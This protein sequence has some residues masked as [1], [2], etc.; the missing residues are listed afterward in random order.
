MIMRISNEAS[1]APPIFLFNKLTQVI[2]LMYD[3]IA[4]H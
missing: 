2:S 1:K 3:T 4:T